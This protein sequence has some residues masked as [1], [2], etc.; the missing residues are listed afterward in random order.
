MLNLGSSGKWVGIVVQKSTPACDEYV[1]VESSASAT[2]K[3]VAH[4]PEASS[5]AQLWVR[6]TPMGRATGFGGL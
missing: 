5:P 3:R 4:C 2:G 1:G 6:A